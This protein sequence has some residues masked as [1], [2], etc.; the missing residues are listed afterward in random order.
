MLNISSIS[1]QAAQALDAESCFVVREVFNVSLAGKAFGLT[2]ESVTPYLKTYASDEA[3]DED[4]VVYGAFVNQALAGMIVLSSTWNN[5]AQIEHIVVAHT[6]R[7]TGVAKSLIEFSKQWAL[8]HHLQGIR[9]ETQTNN[10]PACRL[11]AQCG[12]AL[13]GIDLYAYKTQAHVSN[14]I[15]MYWYWFPEAIGG[16]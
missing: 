16:T 10:V 13:G 15:A 1:E 7:G 9:L 12:F 4:C 3:L 14:E 6:H 8:E 5:L 11:Y 2:V